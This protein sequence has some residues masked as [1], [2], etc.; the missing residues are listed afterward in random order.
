[1]HT[2][3]KVLIGFV[4]VGA[5]AAIF[6]TTMT[7]VVSMGMFLGLATLALWS[8]AGFWQFPDALPRSVSLKTWIATAPRVVEPLATTLAAGLLSTAVALVLTLLCLL[9]EDAARNYDHYLD[10]VR[11]QYGF[12]MNAQRI[13]S[14]HS[15]AACLGRRRGLAGAAA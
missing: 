14:E 3:G 13:V 5:I 11:Y 7:D 6:L 9:R 1:M 15:N 10:G 2:L 8:V 12:A 4:V